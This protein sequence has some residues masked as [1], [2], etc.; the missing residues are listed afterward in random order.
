[1]R[2]KTILQ[3]LCMQYLP[4]LS[5]PFPSSLKSDAFPLSNLIS[6]LPISPYLQHLCKLTPLS[7]SWSIFIKSKWNWNHSNCRKSKYTR[8][9][10]CPQRPIHTTINIHP[11]SQTPQ[12]GDSKS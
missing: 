7:D 5:I 9:P 6:S 1:M 11:K 3:E 12:T 2:C 8:S 10:L 4:D